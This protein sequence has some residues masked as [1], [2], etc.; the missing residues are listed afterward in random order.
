[1]TFSG[2]QVAFFELK[3]SFPEKGIEGKFWKKFKVLLSLG[4]IDELLKCE[5][6]ALEGSELRGL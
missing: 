1:V 5:F 2:S 6:R 3:K 4:T